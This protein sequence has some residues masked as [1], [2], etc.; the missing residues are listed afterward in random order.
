M[1]FRYCQRLRDS[2][3]SAALRKAGGA[4]ES[5]VIAR[6]LVKMSTCLV[7]S[8]KL[9]L[10]N[11]RCWRKNGRGSTAMPNQQQQSTTTDKNQHTSAKV[12]THTRAGTRS[13]QERA[14]SGLVATQIMSNCAFPKA[15]RR[16]LPCGALGQVTQ[17]QVAQSQVT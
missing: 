3:R 9:L 10:P 16:A 17:S 4:L 12:R 6:S 8:R 5:A 11:L 7:G 13:A 1:S 14:H 15:S 2:P